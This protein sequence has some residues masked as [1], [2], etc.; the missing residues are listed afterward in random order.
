MLHG[1]YINNIGAKHVENTANHRK[2]ITKLWQD[3]VFWQRKIAVADIDISVAEKKFK[4]VLSTIIIS[5][6]ANAE[7]IYIF[8]HVK[9]MSFEKLLW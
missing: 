2:K 3:P 9:I 5:T 1:K 7:N 6:F 8:I 4:G